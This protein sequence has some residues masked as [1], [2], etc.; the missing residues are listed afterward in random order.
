MPYKGA[1]WG[2]LL[3][4]PIVAAAFWRDYFAHPAASSIGMHVHG[5]AS[6]L[7]LL[8]VFVQARAIGTRRIGWHRAA[9]TAMFLV[10]PLFTVG[11]LLALQSMA[12]KTE[13]GSAFYHA[14]G[15]R[16]GSV[17]AIMTVAFLW[18]VG[19]SL[20]HRRDPALHGGALLATVLLMLSPV[21]SRLFG[22][23]PFVGA[24]G[25][26]RLARFGWY[27]QGAHL[28]AILIAFVLVCT[29]RRGA[30]AFRAAIFSQV[31]LALAFATAGGSV[32]WEAVFV[33]IGH[34]PVAALV[35]AGIAASVLVLW[36]GWVVG[37][38][39]RHAFN[40]AG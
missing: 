17:D 13:S 37:T 3:L 39:I 15:A 10:V 5:V 38:P 28:V 29:A 30:P 19:F 1:Q 14:F 25:A 18:F 12:Q 11:A 21:L 24:D 8:L 36:R 23:L 40:A 27:V 9:G 35:L 16:L 34:A 2:L 32:A 33:T 31:L 6:M 7:W 22:E 20:R 4:F 26:E